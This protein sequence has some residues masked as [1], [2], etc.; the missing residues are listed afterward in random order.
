MLHAED[1][2]DERDE[3]E[4]EPFKRQ[5]SHGA[6]QDEQTKY[7]SLNIGF[8]EAFLNF[9]AWGDGGHDVAINSDKRVIRKR[10]R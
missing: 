7:R 8:V 1:K 10:C 6:K 5:K 2:G 4:P 9:V 3:P